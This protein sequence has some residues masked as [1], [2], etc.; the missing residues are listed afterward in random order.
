MPI[1]AQP[2]IQPFE[3][4]DGF[5]TRLI[6]VVGALQRDFDLLGFDG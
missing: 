3:T 5:P 2:E 6:P 4:N 1:C